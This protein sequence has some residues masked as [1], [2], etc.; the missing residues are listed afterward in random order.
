MSATFHLRVLF[1]RVVVQFVEEQATNPRF[2]FLINSSPGGTV[3]LMVLHDLPSAHRKLICLDRHGQ[4]RVSCSFDPRASL[5][6]MFLPV[7]SWLS[8]GV[9]GASQDQFAI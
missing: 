7:G 5:K 4:A 6:T 1:S 9:I 2:P 8:A 3:N